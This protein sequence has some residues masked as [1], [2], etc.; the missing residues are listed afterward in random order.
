MSEVAEKTGVE[1]QGSRGWWVEPGFPGWWVEAGFPGL[2]GGARV[3]RAGRWSQVRTNNS[4]E[5]IDH[6]RR[7]I[8]I[9]I[10]S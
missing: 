9:Y 10:R 7:Y 6:Y 1:N 8:Y 3:P 5:V 4:L 2:V